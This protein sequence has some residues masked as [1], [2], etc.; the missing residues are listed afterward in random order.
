MKILDDIGTWWIGRQ[1]SC[2]SCGA[3]IE[4]EQKDKV[5]VYKRSGLVILVWECINCGATN[6][7]SISCIPQ[8]LVTAYKREQERKERYR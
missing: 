4:L 7:D 8:E 6:E 5:R 1:T 2:F 3:N